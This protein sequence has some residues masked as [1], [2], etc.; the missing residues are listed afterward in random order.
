M[1][2]RPASSTAREWI[3]LASFWI[4][5]CRAGESNRAGMLDAWMWRT[6]GDVTGLQAIDLGCGEGR[7]CRML[8]ERG[9]ARVLG[10][11][12]CAPL[13]EAAEEA[14]ASD[15]EHYLL[16]DMQEL[17]G[18]PDAAFDLAVSYISLVDVPDLR[19][20]VA[21]ARRVLKPGG[22]FVVCNLGPMATAINTRMTDPDGA[23]IAFRVDRYFDEST[24]EMRFREHTLTNYHRT[25]AT[26]VNTFIEAG[27]DLVRLFEPYPDAEG[28]ARFPDLANELYAPTFILYDLAVR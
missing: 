28:L 18:V 12:L 1:M 25:L 6:L 24:R 20:A 8:A 14:R 27:F 9:A 16:A 7:F 19:A 13:L 5:R 4:E 23:R 3:D 26:Y 17:S 11:D 22:R 21:A 2:P 10:V 15:R